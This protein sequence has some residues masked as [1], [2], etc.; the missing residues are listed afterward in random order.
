A[1]RNVAVLHAPAAVLPVAGASLPTASPDY[2]LRRDIAEVHLQFSVTD[3]HGSA[4]RNLSAE[5]VRVFDGQAQV[6]RFNQF[7]RDENL[8]LE[9]GVLLDSSDSVRRVLP[10]Q[11]AA[12]TRFLT[13]IMRP[14][15]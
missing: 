7:E 13:R 3:S 11:K 2:T 15:T 12:A 8:P 10:E 6:L 14:G 1:G 9:I 4:V 5:D